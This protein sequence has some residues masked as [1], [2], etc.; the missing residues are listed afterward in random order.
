MTHVLSHLVAHQ[1]EQCFPHRFFFSI[2]RFCAILRVIFF[3]PCEHFFSPCCRQRYSN[4]SR[5]LQNA[6]QGETK[7]TASQTSQ[8]RF[9]EERPAAAADGKAHASQKPG[10]QPRFARP[11]ASD[12]GRGPA[13]ANSPSP[14]PA[15]LFILAANRATAVRVS[16]SR[17]LFSRPLPPGRMLMI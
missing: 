11:V 16:G 5:Q 10:E 9:A 3:S 14:S 12:Q 7:S 8:T 1:C 13:S 4:G 17:S 6:G 2:F 15:L